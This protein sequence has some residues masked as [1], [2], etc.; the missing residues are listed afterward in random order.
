[1]TKLFMDFKT[2]RRIYLNRT[3]GWFSA[4]QDDDGLIDEVEIKNARSLRL[5]PV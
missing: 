4:C 2:K 3:R 1:M 5:E